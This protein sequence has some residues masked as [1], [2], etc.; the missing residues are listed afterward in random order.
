L[1]IIQ[2]V[3]EHSVTDYNF[4]SNTGTKF[5]VTVDWDAGDRATQFD[6]RVTIYIAP[7]AGMVD[8]DTRM[9]E[10][11]LIIFKQ[12]MFVM[13]SCNRKQR[14]PTEEEKFASRKL[15]HQLAKQTM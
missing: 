15:L 5:T 11:T 7:K 8:D 2:P 12:N 10:E 6:D 9:E 4:L 1:D 13:S 3:K 14:Q